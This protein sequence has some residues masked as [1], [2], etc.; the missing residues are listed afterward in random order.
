MSS[1]LKALKKVEEE[2]AARL[3]GQVEIS[4]AILSDKTSGGGRRFPM[5][6]VASA[7]ILIILLAGAGVTLWRSSPPR[8]SASPRAN[9][10]R[11]PAQPPTEATTPPAASPSRPASPASAAVVTRKPAAGQPPSPLPT[12]REQALTQPLRQTPTTP[13]SRPLPAPIAMPQTP[14]ETPARTAPASAPPQAHTV[15]TL[16]VS[17][18]A[19]QKD[20][21]SRL[22]IVNGQPV[23]LGAAVS[24]AT[25]D[26]IFP[27]LVRFSYKGEK[28]EVGLGKSSKGE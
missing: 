1:I 17:G 13:P 26:E 23:G 3:S 7:L 5:P 6:A 25:V 22:A 11:Q 4:R 21:A 8:P 16:R 12:T 27:D 9:A 18:I 20:S 19:W 14:V 2:K 24:G 28:I 15:P 10:P